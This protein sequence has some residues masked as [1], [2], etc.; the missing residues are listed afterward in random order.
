MS[1]LKTPICADLGM[2]YPI[3]LAGMGSTNG[4]TPT[5]PELVAAVSNAGGLG[6][7]GCAGQPP[8]EM[9]RRIKKVRQ[10]TDRPFGVGLLLPA[11]LTEVTPEREE[12]RAQI[13]RDFPQHVAFV[14]QLR[15]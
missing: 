13:R 14:D 10:L 9:W 11:S 2:E 7:L 15:E 12:V 6:V 8:D 4:S 3:F 1:L 5:P